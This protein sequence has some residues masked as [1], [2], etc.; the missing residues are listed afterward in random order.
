MRTPDTSTLAPSPRRFGRV[1][2]A[3]AIALAALTAGGTVVAQVALATG[4]SASNF[5]RGSLRGGFLPDPTTVSITSGGSIDASSAGLPASCRGFVT[6]QPDYI[7]N[8][9]N[10]A[11]FLRLYAVGSGDT[12]LVIN[13]GAGNWH[14]NDDSFGGT[15]PTVD[16]NNPPA[17]QY[18][19]WVGS[20]RAGE[21]IRTTLNI[22][23]L[24]SNHP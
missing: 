10:P 21:N 9:N 11:S 7:L 20:Y 19:V 14:C 24:R 8:Y 16:I 4:G 1:A 17:G 6:R 12:T 23:E 3:A 5:G 22:T 15:N 2:T 13:D 18:D